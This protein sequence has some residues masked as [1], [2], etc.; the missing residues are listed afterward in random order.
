MLSM[1]AIARA[2]GPARL[3]GHER[4]RQRD[5]VADDHLGDEGH[6]GWMSCRR[7]Q[8]GRRAPD[9]AGSCID[10]RANLHARDPTGLQGS[11]LLSP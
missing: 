6:V 1:N 4:D 2:P 5:D 3:C 11:R 8:G 9:H 10:N 7:M